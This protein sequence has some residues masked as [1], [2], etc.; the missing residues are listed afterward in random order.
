ML[1]RRSCL[2]VRARQGRMEDACE[3]VAFAAS[4]YLLFL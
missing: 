2:A 3:L 4:F 1:K